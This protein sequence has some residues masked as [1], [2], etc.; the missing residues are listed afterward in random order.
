MKNFSFSIYTIQFLE[1]K[2]SLTIF[3]LPEHSEDKM[4]NACSIFILALAKI[5]IQ[6]S[7]DRKTLVFLSVPNNFY[8]TGT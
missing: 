3:I 2:I 5:R 7:Q 8:F 1:L 6:L 4:K